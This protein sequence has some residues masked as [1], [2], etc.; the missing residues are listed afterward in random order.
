[1]NKRRTRKNRSASFAFAE[2]KLLSTNKKVEQIQSLQWDTILPKPLGDDRVLNDVPIPETRLLPENFLYADGKNPNLSILRSHFY[3]E[4]LLSPDVAKK[5]LNGAIDIMRKEPN[6]LET[7]APVI[8]V[9]D[10]HGQFYDL[11]TIFDVCPP[12][13]EENTFIF[14][15]DYVDRGNFSTEIL[16]FLCAC[17]INY[18]NRF[19]LLRGNH[20]SRIMAENMTFCNEFLKKYQSQ[21]L[22]KIIF[23]LFDS[24]PIAVRVAT[25]ELGDFLCCHG[26]FSPD[27]ENIAEYNSINR[28]IEPPTNGPLSDILWSDPMDEPSE[29]QLDIATTNEWL[30]IE[31]LDNASR[32]TSYLYGAKSLLRFLEDNNL[33]CI[34]RAHQVMEE[35]Y[36][37]H[38]FLQDVDVPPCITVF[39]APNYCDMY[40]NKGSFMRLMPDSICFE[41]FDAVE[42]PTH[43]PGMMDSISFSLEAL[44]DEL[45]EVVS[46]LILIT[47][48]TPD[49]AKEK[50]EDEILEARIK[51]MVKKNVNKDASYKLMAKIRKEFMESKEKNDIIFKKALEFDK[52]NESKPYEGFSEEVNTS[53]QTKER[54]R[55]R[56]TTLA[57]SR[58]PMKKEIMQQF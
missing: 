48:Y 6:L 7:E 29:D 3:R 27:M 17:K 51:E 5:L 52:M 57:N 16:L 34:V 4:G 14:M 13:N 47:K 39:S 28:F 25:A 32:M 36:R 55:R 42:H 21:D 31:F 12:E 24:F 54:I 43:L 19:L 22:L 53:T 1:M 26:G 46:E 49:N 40:H 50:A 23:T 37:L 41:Q 10:L 58:N 56:A 9:G 20:E 11:L 15:G 45:V 44:M 2:P 33:T 8:I 38:Y 35:G 18:P 30:D